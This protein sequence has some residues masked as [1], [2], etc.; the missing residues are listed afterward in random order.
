MNRE[1]R[2]ALKKQIKKRGASDEKA[3]AYVEFFNNADAIRAGGV[4]VVSPP[5]QINEGDSVTLN[6]ERIKARKNYEKMNPEYQKF[7]EENEGKAFTAHP[8]K[9]NVISLYEDDN[10]WYFWSG[11]LNVVKYELKT[12]G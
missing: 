12:E 4:G 2:R 9:E 8:E 5:N 6:V 1:N 11:D 3:D 7:V 10:K